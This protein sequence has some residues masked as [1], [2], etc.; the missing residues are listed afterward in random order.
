MGS[1]PERLLA[2]MWKAM[3]WLA[4]LAVVPFAVFA[5]AGK[6]IFVLAFGE[7]WA[8]AGVYVQIMAGVFFLR[9]VTSPVSQ[10]FSILERQDLAVAFNVLRLTLVVAGVVVPWTLGLGART[11]IIWYSVAMG[12]TY[13]L[14]PAMQIAAVK[15]RGRTLQK[16][17]R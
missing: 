13:L 16:T 4:A 15:A 1:E 5:A 7:P 8:E 10:N 2:M 11:A 17:A 9:F 12:A 6:P 14:L 3:R